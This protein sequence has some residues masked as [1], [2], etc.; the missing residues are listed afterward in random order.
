M[1]KIT[2]IAPRKIAIFRALQLGDLLCAVPAIRAL[3]HA[4]PDA[5]ITLLGLPWGESFVKRFSAYFSDFIHFPGYPGIIEQPFD[6]KK[7]IAFVEKVNQESFDLVIQMHGNGS[8]I[9]PMVSMLG[10]KRV[11]GYFED[12]SFCPD[13]DLFIPYPEKASEVN[14]HLLLMESL[15][16]PLKGDQLELPVWEGE[17]SEYDQMLI[18]YNLQP[19]KYVCVHPGARDNKRWWAPH[20]FAEVADKLA[21]KGFSIVLTGTKEEGG[22]VETVSSLMKH[23][24]INL[25]GKTSLGSLAELVRNAKLLLSNDTGVSHIAAAVQTPSVIIFLASDPDRWAPLNRNLHNIILPDQAETT[26]N[27]LLQVNRLCMT[28]TAKA[29]TSN[30]LKINGEKIERV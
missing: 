15:R 30:V 22:V 7:Y 3:K 13:S 23:E 4:Y 8:I 9:N 28:E 11:A 16:I 18:K 26:E 6:V 24:A 29:S 1:N 2:E 20:K 19:E 25:V 10:A 12:G 17:K 21:E 27:V 14:K 5:E